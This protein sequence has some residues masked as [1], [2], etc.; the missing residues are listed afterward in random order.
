MCTGSVTAMARFRQH[1]PVT[2]VL[3]DFEIIGDDLRIVARHFENV[4]LID[5]P[6]QNS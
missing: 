2:I 5:V 6:A 4:V 1:Q 3:I